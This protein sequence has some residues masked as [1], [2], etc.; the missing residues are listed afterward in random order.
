MFYFGLLIFLVGIDQVAKFIALKYFGGYVFI[1]SA[2]P[3]SIKGDSYL[4]A[5]LSIVVIIVFLFIIKRQLPKDKGLA[6]PAI[7]ITSGGIGNVI[8]RIFR[9]G[10][11]D[12]VNLKVWPSFN[13]ADALI[14]V[15][16]A[17]I[18]LNEIKRSRSSSRP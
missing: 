6:L 12:F 17:L 2:G 8:D 15:G 18:V 4:F 9:H 14:T 1:N 13:L 5:L 7:L 3:F 16:I 10:V 11:V